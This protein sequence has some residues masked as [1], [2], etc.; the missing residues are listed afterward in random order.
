MSSR[1]K[2]LGKFRLL[3]HVGVYIFLVDGF[4]CGEFFSFVSLCSSL[5]LNRR[6]VGTW[7]RS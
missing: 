2:T 1:I 7:W 5:K 4:A 3:H 6:I